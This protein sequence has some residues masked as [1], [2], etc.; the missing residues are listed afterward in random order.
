MPKLGADFN[1]GDPT[2]AAFVRHPTKSNLATEIRT[3]RARLKDFFGGIANPQSGVREGG[4]FDLES[5]DFKDNVVPP[6]AWVDS[7]TNPSSG[8]DLYTQVTVDRRGF[9]V[10]GSTAQVLNLPRVFRAVYSNTGG[11]F[12][13][14]DGVT[15]ITASPTQSWNTKVL[16]AAPQGGVFLPTVREYQFVVPSGVE[17]LSVIA[18]GNGAPSYAARSAWSTF[19]V[20]PS[21]IYR[22]WVGCTADSPS[23]FVSQDYVR[24]LTSEG[25]P[26]N[27]IKQAVGSL[28]AH[29]VYVNNAGAAYTAADTVFVVDDQAGNSVLQWVPAGAFIHT[30]GGEILRVLSSRDVAG[31]TE[32]TVQRGFYGSTP[33]ATGLADNNALSVDPARLSLN[34]YEVPPF[35][36]YG[37]AGNSV[38]FNFNNVGQPGAVIVEWYA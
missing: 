23:A 6:A 29:D 16:R 13:R 25:F 14:E 30:I 26:Y 34:M 20:S 5:G 19:Q 17:R 27:V 22:V 31:G 2:D 18:I 10:R 21:D 4:L 3:I 9:V 36:P 1:A 8:A 35:R 38:G 11:F 15:Q 24:Y 33:S 7:P 37:M 28:S 32:I 12:E